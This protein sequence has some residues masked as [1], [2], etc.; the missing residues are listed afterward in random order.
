MHKSPTIPIILSAP[1]RNALSVAPERCVQCGDELNY[2]YKK[3]R[4]NSECTVGGF[5][6]LLV[7]KLVR[8][9]TNRLYWDL[10]TVERILHLKPNEASGLVKALEAAGL[11]KASRGRS[12]KKWTTTQ[13]AQSFASATAAKP[14]TRQTAEKALAQFL[15]CVN[16][17]NLD[18][19][20][21]ANVT[22]VILFG[23]YL[24]PEVKKLGD[25]D[26]GVELQPKE[27]DRKRLR[28]LN[29]QRVE[30]FENSHR[31]SRALDRGVVARRDVPIPEGEEPL[32]KP[33]RLSSRKRVCGP[34][35]AQGA[36][37]SA[38]GKIE[39]CKRTVERD[40]ANK[41]TE[42]LPI[43]NFVPTLQR[44]QE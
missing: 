34:S 41:T 44:G 7:R 5:P 40:S 43:L 3:M 24:N 19:R 32:D 33:A 31:F 12:P 25:V 28:E 20:F 22:L 17:V 23:S 36:L 39:A 4:I 18:D 13:L 27:S 11:A 15:E 9:L 38:T 30:Q 37:F 29:Y 6:A 2:A 14:I 42:R 1:L 16:R 21:L 10:E 8:A 35:T 26:V